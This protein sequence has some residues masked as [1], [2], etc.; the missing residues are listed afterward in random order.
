VEPAGA[1]CAAASW[2][3]ATL[4]KL[5]RNSVAAPERR[6]ARLARDDIVVLILNRPR[7]SARELAV[8]MRRPLISTD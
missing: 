2:E 6:D 3:I 5:D 8:R 1:A 7:T 4:P